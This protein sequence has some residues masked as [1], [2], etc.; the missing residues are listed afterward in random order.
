MNTNSQ[1]LGVWCGV[2]FLV[3]FGLGWW[4]LAGYLPPT[5]PALSAN[6]IAAFYQENTG[7]I[8]LGLM[9]TMFSAILVA[10]WVAVI[11]VQMKRIE[12]DY[13]VLAYTMLVAGAAGIV[14][15]FL[16][17]MIWTTAAFRPERDAELIMLLNDFGWLLFVMTFSPFFVQNMAVGLAIF[18]DKAPVPIFPRWLG[19]LNIWVAILLVPGG[20]VTFFKVGPFAWDGIL[21]FWMPL[22][23]FFGWFLVMAVA[24]TKAIKQQAAPAQ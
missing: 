16:P 20:V 9:I 12:G 18:S 7:R 4:L 8:R 1:L 15:L 11:A 23:V 5:S 14:I 17:A 13:P 6:E 3:L 2:G 21:A 22:V 10:P 19:Y 24:L